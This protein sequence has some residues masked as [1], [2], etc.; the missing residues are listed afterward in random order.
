[1]PLT[2]QILGWHGTRPVLSLQTGSCARMPVLT[3]NRLDSPFVYM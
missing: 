2:N 1:M 3:V